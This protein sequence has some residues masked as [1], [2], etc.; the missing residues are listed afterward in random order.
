MKKIS[1]RQIADIGLFLLSLFGVFHLALTLLR[2]E[3]PD[4]VT[5]Y[6][7]LFAILS[8]DRLVFKK[9]TNILFWKTFFVA[10]IIV[11][12]V[13]DVSL[14]SGLVEIQ[15]VYGYEAWSD[16]W[17]FMLLGF[18]LLNTITILFIHKSYKFISKGI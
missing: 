15:R 6:W 3:V 14:I 13:Q 9:I 4:A 5:T 2:S 18:A 17:P 7:A 12:A 8:F 1:G 11:L 10:G 16:T